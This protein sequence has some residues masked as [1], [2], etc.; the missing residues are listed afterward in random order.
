MPADTY[1][2]TVPGPL[3]CGRFALT[4]DRPRVMG[5]LNVTPDSFSDG[6]RFVDRDAALAHARR[7]LADGADIIDVGAESTRPGAAPAAEGDEL[8]RVVPI[9]EALREECAARGA[10][11]SIDTRKPAVMRA[12]IAAGAGMVNDIGALRAPGALEAVAAAAEPVGVCLMHMQGEPATMQLHVVYT[13][14]VS[15]VK[16]FLAERAAACERA[17]IAGN[18]IAIDPGFGFGKTVAHNLALL[19]WLDELVALGYPVAVGLS[20]KST[21]G[22]LTG[23]DVGERVAGS[24]AAALAAVERGAAIVRVH[25]VRE[26][27][28]AL[29][30]WRAVEGA[31]R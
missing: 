27:V 18:R 9:L 30:V 4:L 17:G 20:R 15:E 14:V 11:L 22:A 10:V 3:R 13:D 24:V 19:R 8:A 16:S 5:V 7:M 28:D 6:G 25:D 2:Y 1:A 12:A 29:S 21:I 31:S 26:T 23:R